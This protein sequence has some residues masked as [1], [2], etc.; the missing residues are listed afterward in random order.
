MKLL[1]VYTWWFEITSKNLLQNCLCKHHVRNPSIENSLLLLLEPLLL[2]LEPVLP[3]LLLLL[4]LLL[5][6]ELELRLLLVLPEL[7]DELINQ[8]TRKGIQCMS[9]TSGKKCKSF[10]AMGVTVYLFSLQLT[11][12]LFGPQ[13][14][15]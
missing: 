2:R 11:R 1:V 15:T 8:H 7:E 6:P 9:E 14:F 10:K 12:E 13:F 4:P 3:E 5:E